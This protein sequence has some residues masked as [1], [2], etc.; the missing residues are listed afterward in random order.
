MQRVTSISDAGSVLDLVADSLAL[1]Q[2]DS[3]VAGTIFGDAPQE[4][5]VSGWAGQVVLRG[6]WLHATTLCN[7]S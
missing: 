6:G 2:S 3:P 5:A 4:G 1:A 7:S